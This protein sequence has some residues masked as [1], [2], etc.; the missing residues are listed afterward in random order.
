MRSRALYLASLLITV[1]LVL[2]VA[3]TLDTRGTSASPGTIRYVST[4]GNDGFDCSSPPLRC[5]T[6]QRAIEAATT[7]DEIRVATGVYTVT[8]G[9]VVSVTKTVTLKGG[10]DNN[11]FIR[12]PD[13]YPTIL[14]AQGQGRV[15]YIYG[16]ISPTIDGF[17][18]TGGNAEA[19]DHYPRQGGGIFSVGANPTIHKNVITNN[20][21]STSTSAFGWGGGIYLYSA[22][23]LVSGNQIL[24]NTAS[25]ADVGYG[26]GLYLISSDATLSGNTISGNTASTVPGSEGGG[27]M[28]N[29]SNATLDGNRIISNTA[30]GGAGLNVVISAPFTLTNNV[31]AQNQA[32][33]VAGGIRVWGSS[34]LPT[35]GALINNTIAQNNLGSGKDGVYAFGTTTLTLTN[36]IVISHTYGIYVVPPATA[37]ADYTLFFDNTSGDTGGS[38]TSTNEVSGDPLF[39][40][41]AA[42]DYHIQVA[43]PAINKGTFTG[44]PS[45]D[46]EGDPRPHDCFV[47]I[48]AD[49][50]MASG[51]CQRVY[52]PLI[53]KNH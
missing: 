23:A 8:A 42:W 41:L 31:I 52:L 22:S 32:D 36:N 43:S 20:I 45:T 47:D 17:I 30:P 9:T 1:F 33:G 18:I 27:V 12:N 28:L 39:V 49:E 21:A 16:A 38:I 48:G 15:V 44:A 50:N 14:D 37:T 11:F 40:D 3:A 5:R 26:G 4:T 34:A 24:S 51:Y 2:L 25:T 35:S 53:F 46:F 19:A 13:S 7:G 6:V 10:W 29:Y